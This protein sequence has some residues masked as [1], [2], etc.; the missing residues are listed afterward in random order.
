ML[1][2]AS[3]NLFRLRQQDEQQV[4]WMQAAHS[5]PFSLVDTGRAAILAWGHAWTYSCNT[6]Q[7]EKS[8]GFKSNGHSGQCPG[9]QNP[10]CK[11]LPRTPGGSWQC[12]LGLNPS[13]RHNFYQDI[14]SE[15][16]GPHALSEAFDRHWLWPVCQWWQKKIMRHF[17]PLLASSICFRRALE[18]GVMQM[19]GSTSATGMLT[20]STVAEINCYMS[21]RF[22]TRKNNELAWPNRTSACWIASGSL[23]PHFF[24]IWGQKW[25]LNNDTTLYSIPNSSFTRPP[26]VLVSLLVMSCQGPYALLRIFTDGCPEPW[27]WQLCSA[28]I[29]SSRPL[30]VLASPSSFL[31]LISRLLLTLRSS[32]ILVWCCPSW[33]CWLVCSIITETPPP[34]P[35][36]VHSKSD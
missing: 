18:K 34:H 26:I 32:Q 4:L 2:N 3:S 15:F 22:F 23:L 5:Q 27:Q 31:T 1:F 17:W 21:R 10:Q 19:L 33:S 16:R 8:I 30:P 36:T 12:G 11:S 20:N 29:A 25:P 24:S 35:L 9:V 6:F 28:P 13:R 14:S 7:M